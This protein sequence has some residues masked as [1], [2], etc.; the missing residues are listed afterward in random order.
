M[1]A[2]VGGS[3]Q[4]EEKRGA[5]CGAYCHKRHAATPS[6]FFL[7]QARLRLNDVRRQLVPL[8]FELREPRRKGLLFSQ[9]RKP[10]RKAGGT[11]IPPHLLGACHRNVNHGGGCG[12]RCCDQESL[13]YPNTPKLVVV[14]HLLRFLRVSRS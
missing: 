4:G 9:L 5:T 2:D 7:V 12:L 10:H 3:Q 6:I 8:L 14:V 1:K 13:W 11:T